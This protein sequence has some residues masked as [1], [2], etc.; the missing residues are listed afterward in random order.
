MI[1]MI[2][3]S[4]SEKLKSIKDELDQA[5]YEFNNAIDPDLIDSAIYKINSINSVYKYYLNLCQVG[6]VR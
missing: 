5:Y 2:H 6:R 4:V 3:M 1:D